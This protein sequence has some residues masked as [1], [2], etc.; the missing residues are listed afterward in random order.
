[1]TFVLVRKLLRD[2]RAPLVV[3]ALFLA[4][5]Q[6]LWVKITERVTG[7]LAPLFTGL[8]MAQGM[9]HHDLQ[10]RVFEGP[11]R[12][13]QTLIGG[14]TIELE[15]VMHTLSIGYVH[16]LM[17]AVFCVWAVGR[18]SGA[19]AG[20]I[21]RGTM[22]LLLSQPLAR[23]Q[24]VLA[25]LCVDLFTIPILCL[26]LWAGTALGVALFTPIR[27]D[28]KDQEFEV[29]GRK[30]T[31]PVD[32]KALEVEPAKF[33]RGLSNVG[34][35]LFAVSGGSMWLSARGR[36]RGRVLGAAVLAVLVQFL[37]NLLGQLWDVLAPLRPLTVFYWF[38]P[39]QLILGGGAGVDLNVWTGGHPLLRINA[40][41]VL[42][43]AGAAGYGLAL[44]T[45]TRRDVPA[46]L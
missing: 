8:A 20:E 11:E 39:Q 15:Y 28:P 7:K 29:M 26:S 25:H 21:D 14:E 2:V 40:V 13:I 46:P 32:P 33:G 19:L 17:Q 44:W 37:V 27:I 30:A 16:P 41:A 42:L 31:V 24:L 3:V 1:M 12:I 6:C 34:A 38:R 43:L 45:F 35:L 36:F 10:R 23:R 5:F 22:E 4:L 18:A 9:T